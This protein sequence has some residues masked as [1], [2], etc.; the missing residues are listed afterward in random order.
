MGFPHLFLAHLFFPPVTSI[1]CA[2]SDVHGTVRLLISRSIV[3]SCCRNFACSQENDGR[4]TYGRNWQHCR[5]I[6]WRMKWLGRLT[7]MH[8]PV[9]CS[10][11][12]RVLPCK[13]SPVASLLSSH[14]HAVSYFKRKPCLTPFLLQTLSRSHR[15]R[16]TPLAFSTAPPWPLVSTCS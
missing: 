15:A 3:G 1:L 8:S 12:P 16:E 13:A 2:K 14:L 10:S 4:N 9:L 7:P 11:A 6:K 5:E